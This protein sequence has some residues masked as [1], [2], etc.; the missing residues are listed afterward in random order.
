LGAAS[1]IILELGDMGYGVP[2]LQREGGSYYR[3]S[4][5][6][7]SVL[8]M[9]MRLHM[10]FP[11]E[12]QGEFSVNAGVELFVFTPKEHRRPDLFRPG[13]QDPQSLVVDEDVGH[14]TIVDEPNVYSMQGATISVRPA[15]AQ[16]KK[17]S[18]YAHGGE[19]LYL[20]N[21]LPMLKVVKGAPD[22]PRQGRAALS[23]GDPT[24]P[25]SDPRA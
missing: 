8:R 25:K 9:A 18:L 10:M 1:P 6:T 17:T 4:D 3:I 21:A 14:D 12:R 5:G 19:P 24:H 20:V 7:G 16:I 11:G 13:L 15:I 22:A 23:G 2:V